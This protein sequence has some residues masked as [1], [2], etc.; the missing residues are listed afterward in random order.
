MANVAELQ[1]KVSATGVAQ[2]AKSLESLGKAAQSYR[3]DI[4]KVH[5]TLSEMGN[6]KLPVLGKGITQIKS[7]AS[8][9]TGIKGATTSF[10]KLANALDRMVAQSS[11]LGEVAKQ[12]RSIKNSVTAMSGVRLNIGGATGGGSGGS[13]GGMSDQEKL[14]KQISREGQMA[15]VGY[16]KAAYLEQ[17]AAMLGVAEAAK[18]YIAQMRSANKVVGTGVTNTRAYTNA[19]RLVPAQFTDVVTQLAGGQNPFL[20]MI[21]QGGQLADVFRMAGVSFTGMLKAVGGKALALLLNP[22][23]ALVAVVGTLAYSF[24]NAS[25]ETSAFAKVAAI[26]GKTT[27]VTVSSLQSAAAQA[28]SFGVSSSMAAEAVAGLAAANV[29]SSRDMGELAA[30]ASKYSKVMGVDLAKV[31]AEYIGLNDKASDKM[32]QLNQKY[33]NLTPVVYAQVVALEKEGKQVEAVKLANEELAKAQEKATKDT[34]QNIGLVEKAWNGVKSAVSYVWEGILSIGRATAEFDRLKKVEGIIGGITDKID[35]MTAAGKSQVEIDMQRGMLARWNN[36]RDKILERIK[37]K[38]DEQNLDAQKVKENDRLLD[39]MKKVDALGDKAPSRAAAEA[40]WQKVLAANIEAGAEWTKNKAE[41]AARHQK[42][43][44]G[45]LSLTTQIAKAGEKSNNSA[46]TAAQNHA[47]IVASLEQQIADGKLRLAGL[48]GEDVEY[49]KHNE[50]LSKAAAL[51]AKAGKES[52]ATTKENMLAEAALEEKLGKILQT[53]WSINDAEKQRKALAEQQ[54]AAAEIRKRY[55]E[56]ETGLLKEQEDQDLKKIANL[57]KLTAAE[58]ARLELIVRQGGARKQAE[59][60]TSDLGNP[61]A[62]EEMR[63][64]KR[65]QWIEQNK[66][67]LQQLGVYESTIAEANFANE[68]NMF[69][70]KKQWFMAQSQWNTTLMTTMDAVGSSLSSSLAGVIKGTTSLKD[71]FNSLGDA[72]LNSV[73]GALVQMGVQWVQNLVLSQAVAAT[74]ASLLTGAVT[75]QVAMTSALAAQNAFAAT[76]ATPIVGPALAPAAATAAGV[77]AQAIGTPA[78][79]LAPVAGA[80]PMMD[81][82]GILSPGQS[83]VVGEYGREI[84][85]AGSSPVR[86]TSR[87]ETER[88][89]G[90]EGGSGG[91]QVNMKVINNAGVDVQQTVD[92]E[93][94]VVMVLEKYLPNMLAREGSNPKSKLNQAQSSIYAQKRR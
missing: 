89:M 14:M 17:R 38:K 36:E 51:R 79:A 92:T 93:G 73:V 87:K 44:E 35:E 50:H 54:N 60:F 34:L 68:Q 26:A 47:G 39:A 25:G 7:L 81:N 64:N 63:H 28:R 27:G 6:V 2:F 31:I 55:T 82:G 21:Q 77:A 72:I 29:V 66:I 3:A 8:A 23:T 1:I 45:E 94:N 19:M 20:I 86:V 22:V 70:A 5:T 41:V 16:D 91:T 65:M 85:T 18:P 61:I 52:N 71:M 80:K 43:I 33:R 58:K 12:L 42:Y 67:A 10:T 88:M 90:V 84:I 37:V 75:A 62:N 57:D 53:I 48:K 78:I 46:E 24:Y 9:T 56:T 76:A 30:V 49:Q 40:M 11:G 83:A 4:K 32:L 59:Q 15:S 69:N 13:R 74:N